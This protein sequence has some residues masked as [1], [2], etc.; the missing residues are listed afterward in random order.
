MWAKIAAS[1]KLGC[2][3]CGWVGDV[4]FWR[5]S[6][7]VQNC[8]H[9][10]NSQVTHSW[11]YIS[12]IITCW[13]SSRENSEQF[14]SWA[15]QE[16]PPTILIS[17]STL[18]CHCVLAILV[19]DSVHCVGSTQERSPHIDSGE[20]CSDI[21]W[22]PT[23]FI[24]HAIFPF[25]RVISRLRSLRMMEPGYGC[26]SSHEPLGFIHGYIL[27]STGAGNIHGSSACNTES[28]IRD[29]Y[30]SDSTQSSL[31]L[32][33][34]DRLFFSNYC[35]AFVS[36]FYPRNDS[37]E[38]L[39]IRDHNWRWVLWAG[40][41]M[42]TPAQVQLRWLCH[43]WSKRWNRG[44][45]VGKYLFATL[46]L[47]TP[48]PFSFNFQNSNHWWFRVDPGCGVDI[49][50]ICY[51]LSFAP[52]TEFTKFFPSQSEILNYI[53]RVAIQYGVCNHFSGETE[54]VGA[55]WQEEKQ[56][57]LVKLKDLKTGDQFT[58]ECRILIS[59]VGGLVNPR[60]INIRGS[61]TL[62][63]SIIHTARWQNDVDLRDK[64]VSVIGN[65]GKCDPIVLWSYT[66]KFGA[67]ARV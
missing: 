38:A 32:A 65:G 6:S 49:P 53:H 9:R 7:C 47:F 64:Q 11:F 29:K 18:R 66:Q 31:Y 48:P 23:P 16:A 62:K 60:N 17:V 4:K 58:Q 63:G 27:R 42:P 34:Y 41:G 57:W 24:T 61:E 22:P 8:G 40:Y 56:L 5:T 36:S 43:L 35:F 33:I 10:D 2:P 30:H 39:I 13:W 54:W 20:R 44:C 37:F 21:Q 46:I 28:W 55:T 26:R 52:N 1:S 50:G 14:K 15:S 25:R 3:R 59:G 45:L 51:S 19:K 67:L 12:D